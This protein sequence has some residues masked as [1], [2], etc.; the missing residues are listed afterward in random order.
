MHKI[1]RDDIVQVLRGKD[2][3]KKGKVLRIVREKNRAIVEGINLIKKHMRQRR[4]DQPGGIVS[5]E[6]AINISNLGLFCKHCNR[7]VRTGFKVLGD[8]TKSR[9]CKKCKEVI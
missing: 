3:G 7:P 6:A 1:R 5:V 2:K 8:A 9:F 4:Q